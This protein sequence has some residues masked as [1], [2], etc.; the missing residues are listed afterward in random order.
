MFKNIEKI[1]VVLI[2]LF[3]LF[4]VVELGVNYFSFRYLFPVKNMS[5]YGYISKKTKKTVIPLN[6]YSSR[7]ASQIALPY[8]LI[9]YFVISDKKLIRIYDVN[10]N[11]FGYA[12]E[13]GKKIIDYKFD[14]AFEFNNDYA[15]V[16]VNKDNNQ[17]FGTI[18]KNGNW[19]IKPKYSYLC[20]FNKYHTK[21]CIDDKHCGIID[22]FGNEITL[23]SYKTDKLK[24][25][26]TKC[27]D[28]FCD[29]GKNKNNTCN[30]FL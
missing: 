13:K 18:D 16:S 9:C 26:D 4:V 12:S 2:Y 27:I 3:C 24:C 21:A 20:P 11:K 5:S 17:K 15:I 14:S 7:L 8:E 10:T 29:I 30:Y 6:K 25:E 23:M 28:K 19:V 1:S 22:R